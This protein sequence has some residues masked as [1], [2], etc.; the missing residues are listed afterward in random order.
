MLGGC[1]DVWEDAIML[2]GCEDVGR[3]R[4]CW[5]GY[6]ELNDSSG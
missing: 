5:E 1:E 3:M 2:G 4:G 6:L